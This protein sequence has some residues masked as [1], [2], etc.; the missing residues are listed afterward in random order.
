MFKC[1]ECEYYSKLSYNVQRHMIIRH[2]LTISCK[3]I[4]KKH[5]DN[6]MPNLN[7]ILPNQC[8][9]CNKIYS[10][11]G[12]LNMHFKICKGIN[13]KECKFCQRALSSKQAKES[14]NSHVK[15]KICK[16]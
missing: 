6:I 3:D 1:I 14:I 15:I 11:K 7:N 12:I 10:S 13:N 8:E 4:L 2:N 9:K 16:L 5:N